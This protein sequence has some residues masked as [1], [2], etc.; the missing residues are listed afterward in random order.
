MRAGGADELHPLDGGVLAG[1]L[2]AAGTATT[3]VDQW[4]RLIHGGSVPRYCGQTAALLIA[5]TGA[6]GLILA[7]TFLF[8][9][10]TEREGYY[11]PRRFVRYSRLG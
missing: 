7:V 3:Y 6:R 5:P 8:I 10:P 1:L 9:G 4:P 2:P 11:W